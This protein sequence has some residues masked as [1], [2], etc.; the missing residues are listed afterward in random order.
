MAPAPN[1]AEAL[2]TPAASRIGA[3]EPLRCGK[4]LRKNLWEEEP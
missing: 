4:N 3:A 2:T 1:G